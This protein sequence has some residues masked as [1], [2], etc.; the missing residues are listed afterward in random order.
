MG[1]DPHQQHPQHQAP[2]FWTAN[3]LTEEDIARS[4]VLSW[5]ASN[6]APVE[7]SSLLECWLMSPIAIPV[8]PTVL[9]AVS[10]IRPIQGFVLL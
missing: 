10:N 9:P 2:M 3:D 8:L 5:D 7:P 6:H 1:L 4:F